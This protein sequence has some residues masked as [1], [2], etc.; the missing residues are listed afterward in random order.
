[1][2]LQALD[3]SPLLE[4]TM[5]LNKAGVSTVFYDSGKHSVGANGWKKYQTAIP[6]KQEVMR[7]FADP[8]AIYVGALGGAVSGNLFAIDFDDGGSCYVPFME[9]LKKDRP[10]LMKRLYVEKSPNGYHI[11]ARSAGTVC[12][13]LNIYKTPEANE[14]DLLIEVRGE[15]HGTIIAP[16]PGYKAL[17]GNLLVSIPMVSVEDYQYLVALAKRFDK[18]K[19]KGLS[20]DGQKPGEDF[21]T[22]ATEASVL[23]MLLDHGWVETKKSS[24]GIQLRRPGKNRGSS[25]TLIT[26]ASPV[27]FH[28]F[29]ASASPFEADE[30]YGPFRV[31]AYLNHGG[32]YSAAGKALA[33]DGY[34]DK[35][36]VAT[37]D[38][39]D[40]KTFK[41]KIQWSRPVKFGRKVELPEVDHTMLPDT[42]FDMAATVSKAQQISITTTGMM[43]VGVAASACMGKFRVKVRTGYFEH[44]NAYVATIAPPGERKTSTLNIMAKPIHYWEEK[45]QDRWRPG[46]NAAWRKVKAIEKRLGK[47]EENLLEAVENGTGHGEIEQQIANLEQELATARQ[48]AAMPRLTTSQGT[49]EAI[50]K[51]LAENNEQISLIH[52][53][54][55]Q[56]DILLGA[57]SD[58]AMCDI[59]LNAWD[60]NRTVIDRVKR[61]ITTLKSPLMTIV[62]TPQPA[63]LAQMDA[64]TTAYKRGL[65][66]RFFFTVA[67]SMMGKRKAEAPDVHP[68]IEDR[69]FQQIVHLLRIELERPMTLTLS[70]DARQIG[71]QFFETLEGRI[72]EYDGDLQQMTG[73]V[74]K[75]QGRVHSLAGIFHLIENQTPGNLLNEAA[76]L[77]IDGFTME[78]ATR[79]GALLTDHA[80]AA[81]ELM[82]PDTEDNL[83]RRILQWAGR[84][85]TSQTTKRELF[86]TFK[87]MSLVKR[88]ED[89]EPAL[90][91]LE[92][93]DWISRAKVR[94]SGRGRPSECILFHPRLQTQSI[95]GG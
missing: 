65:P 38:E 90:M 78:M 29:S 10:D 43:A 58:K 72:A 42:M 55:G 75:M 66:H 76:N 19:E 20:G 15:A 6:T 74:S 77:E 59:F 14:K 61:G 69:Y 40:L 87:N 51:V 2:T 73:W 47:K 26:G 7:D 92:S 37:V 49:D 41:D 79:L 8:K 81:F 1:M 22:Q 85:R 68:D 93:M 52:S 13:R 82:N 12:R 86:Q 23:N 48:K 34:G 28:N 53:E 33:A 17:Q 21:D 4:A 64:K 89:I 30:T 25:A 62:L 16:S 50:T 45:L 39:N 44:C 5:T 18:K 70:D 60:G 83:A 84:K 11:V 56:I 9:A 27:R 94:K 80:A 54:A 63:A 36:S 57:Y 88:T 32:D 91:V 31:Y 35:G 71:M 67:P 95:F 3:R 46:K 24:V